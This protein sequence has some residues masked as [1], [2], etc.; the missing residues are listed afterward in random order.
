MT[1]NSAKDRASGTRRVPVLT[2]LLIA[3]NMVAAFALFVYPDFAVELGFRPNHPSLV[4][5]ITGLFLHANLFH[6]LGNM[7]FL[8]AV[9]AAVEGG[10]ARQFATSAAR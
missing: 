4:G 5:A 6:L 7:V 8:A 9:G 10:A 2:L 1:V 3:A